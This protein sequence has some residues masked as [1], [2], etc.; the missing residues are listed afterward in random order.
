MEKCRARC[1]GVAL[2]HGFMLCIGLASL[3]LSPLDKIIQEKNDTWLYKVLCLHLIM[4]TD[5]ILTENWDLHPRHPS[6]SST[7]STNVSCYGETSSLTN[8]Q[9]YSH[10][11]L[12]LLLLRPCRHL[13]K[14]PGDSRRW[15]R[16]NW[17]SSRRNRWQSG[18]EVWQQSQC[19]Q[20]LPL[21]AL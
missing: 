15:A 5:Q 10:P 12:Q 17:K 9:T 16:M 1:S 4:T 3:H 18:Q 21:Q 7:P 11:F 6:S 14:E 8:H 2:S 19:R 20:W 13:H